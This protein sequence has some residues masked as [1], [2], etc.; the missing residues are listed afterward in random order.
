MTSYKILVD[1][2]S[3]SHA[4]RLYTAEFEPPVKDAHAKDG[5]LS[6]LSRQNFIHFAERLRV[7]HDRM[8]AE[9]KVE[10][11]YAKNVDDTHRKALRT[12]LR[13]V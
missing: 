1:M 2:H 7:Y 10:I 11:E 9:G 4:N 5:H 3:T 8:M 12:L 6:R 13:I